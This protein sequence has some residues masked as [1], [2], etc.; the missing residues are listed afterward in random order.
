MSNEKKDKNNLAVS[1]NICAG[2][3]RLTKPFSHPAKALE[4]SCI[5]HSFLLSY[6]NVNFSVSIIAL[7]LHICQDYP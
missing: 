5:G 2:L 4:K 3:E 1:P 7:L 6:I